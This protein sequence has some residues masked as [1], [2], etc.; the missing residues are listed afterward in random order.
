MNIPKSKAMPQVRIGMIQSTNKVQFSCEGSFQAMDLTGKILVHGKGNQEYTVRIKETFPAKMKYRVRLAIA[1]TKEEARHIQARLMERGYATELKHTGLVIDLRD[2]TLDN[3][4][5]WIVTDPFADRAAADEFA[6]R[7]EPV[8]EAVV[9]K[10]VLQKPS[11]TLLL[12]SQEFSQGVR[13]VP[14]SAANRISLA[15]VTVGIEFHWQH[16]RTQVLPGILEVGINNAGELV[17]INELDIEDYLVSVNSSE[18]TAENPPELLKAQTIAARSTILATMGKH[19]YDESFHLCA[20]DH[21]QCYHGMANIAEASV[22][23]ARD[24]KGEN[25]MYGERVCD[26]RYAKICGGVMEDYGKVWDNRQVPYLVAGVDGPERIE[27]PLDNEEKV[28]AYIDSNPDVY[29]NTHR[30]KISSALPYDSVKLFRWRVSYSREELQEIIHSKI[31]GAI[32]QLIDLVPGERGTSGRLIY[33]DIVGSEK[34]VRVGKEL[35]IRRALSKSHLYSA[36]FYV[37]RDLDDSGKITHF[38]LIGAGWG[39]GVGLCQVGATVM[40]QKGFDYR[41]I[42][43]HYYRNSTL[44]KLY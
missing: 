44:Q 13:I 16:Q 23:A 43:A 39:H 25:L 32:G 35:Q 31:G 11:G 6:R 34:T 21:C 8:G 33:L 42:L 27:F 4:D 30:Y 22:R 7:Y 12:D 17:A 41:A 1:E 10:D 28:R 2:R 3:R 26:A 18:M 38:H 14:N 15:N 24:T 20:D 40:A 36:C 29:C 9:V 37:E 19:H 5:Y